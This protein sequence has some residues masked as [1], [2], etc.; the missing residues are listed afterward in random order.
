MAHVVGC[1]DRSSAAGSVC[2]YAAWASSRLAVPLTLLHVMD[3]KRYME[4]ARLTSSLN[5]RE[6]SLEEW[7]TLDAQRGK[8]AKA[9]A[10]HMLQEAEKRVRDA[11]VEEVHQRQRTGKFIEALVDIETETKFFVMGLQGEHSSGRDLHVGSQLETVIRRINAPIFLVPNTFKAPQRVML[12]FDGSDTMLNIIERMSASLLLKGLTLHLVMIG[13]DSAWRRKQLEN[14]A[15]LLAPTG[16]DIHEVIRQGAVDET[17]RKY[18]EH[19]DIDLLIMGAH[20]H[21]RI[22]QFLVGSTTTN[23]LETSKIPLIV[24]R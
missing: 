22:R 10:D 8:L 9:D 18:Q 7:A 11:G 24:M 17:L 20:G 23:M 21:S 16:S 1:V 5:N 3:Q 6:Y 2:D 15:K 4:P 19:N 13:Q 14:A 12:A